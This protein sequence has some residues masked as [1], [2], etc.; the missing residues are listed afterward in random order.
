L[1]NVAS[2]EYFKAVD[3]RLFSEDVHIVHCVFKDAGKVV[4]TYAK[5]A[6]GLMARYITKQLS[7][8]PL[9]EIEAPLEMLK[10][11]HEEGYLYQSSTENTSQAET[12][13]TFHRHASSSKDQPSVSKAMSSR[14]TKKRRKKEED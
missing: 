7:A 11:F 4:S 3:P 2:E 6:R 13:I 9:A 1:V 8:T 14:R 10:G 12:F 5:R